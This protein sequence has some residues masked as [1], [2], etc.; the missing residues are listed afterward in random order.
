MFHWCTIVFPQRLLWFLRH[1][2]SVQLTLELSA[3]LHVHCFWNVLFHVD[4][5][6]RLGSVLEK[7]KASLPTADSGQ[8]PQLQANIAKLT[9]E[10]IGE[11]AVVRLRQS[12]SH[13]TV[14]STDACLSVAYG[15]AFAPDVLVGFAALTHERVLAASNSYFARAIARHARVKKCF[16]ETAY[17]LGISMAGA[18]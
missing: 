5:D 7:M 11:G 12:C 4:R 8:V 14:F 16:T 6:P 18:S 9:S 17:R 10:N 15:G 3:L 2:Q 13:N 1:T